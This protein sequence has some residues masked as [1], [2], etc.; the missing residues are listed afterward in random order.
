ML[1]ISIT[2]NAAERVSESNTTEFRATIAR[3]EMPNPNTG[4]CGI[5]HTEQYKTMLTLAQIDRI[6][7]M[8]DFMELEVG[9]EV[10][11]RIDSAWLGHFEE[12]NAITIV[13]LRTDEKEIASLNSYSDLKQKENHML[14]VQAMVIS[15]LFL[16]LS[17]HC[18]LL[19]R[20][21]NIFRRFKKEPL[22]AYSFPDTS[23]GQ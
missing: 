16:L 5:I 21:I 9:Q 3:I 8:D 11:F 7:D 23:A 6:I 20:G 18:V 22:P 13:S 1:I 19:L 10:F 12:M 17:V 14:S 4:E 2:T 15:L